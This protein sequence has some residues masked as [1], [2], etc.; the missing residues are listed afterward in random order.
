[1]KLQEIP[2]LNEKQ[3]GLIE[4]SLKSAVRKLVIYGSVDPLFLI[5]NE[6]S[7][8]A[9]STQFTG[10]QVSSKNAF[11]MSARKLARDMNATFTIFISEAWIAHLSKEEGETFRGEVRTRPDRKEAI[12]C[13]IE[14]EGGRKIQ[15]QCVFG[16]GKNDVPVPEEFS[17]IEGE[18]TGMQGRF[19]GILPT[20]DNELTPE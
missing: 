2:N 3:R 6:T 4:G 18:G 17:F 16:R 15:G 20:E 8:S 10:P 7:V 12:I 5:G 11:A 14:L 9:I 19:V 1:M 13:V